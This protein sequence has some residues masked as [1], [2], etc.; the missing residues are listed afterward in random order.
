MAHIS[1]TW[2]WNNP[3]SGVPSHYMRARFDVDAETDG[4]NV[5]V[6]IT[7]I[8]LD[9]WNGADPD[10]GDTQD[11]IVIAS[12]G[13]SLPGTAPAPPRPIGLPFPS[14]LSAR[15]GFAE[16]ATFLNGGSPQQY[17]WQAG[18]NFSY[19]IPYTGPDMRVVYGWYSAFRGLDIEWGVEEW[20]VFLRDLTYRPGMTREN[21]TNS[22]QSDNRPETGMNLEL[23]GGS[24]GEIRSQSAY[25]AAPTQARYFHAG[26][27]WRSQDKI[28]IGR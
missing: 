8:V 20:G 18:T 11:H 26:Q 3:H 17:Y 14:D 28:G 7:N 13:T 2:Q 4:V 9:G 24:W 5:N 25:S 19:T 6:F 15:G 27:G 1:K 16:L 10:V 12:N 23:R 22:W 21:S